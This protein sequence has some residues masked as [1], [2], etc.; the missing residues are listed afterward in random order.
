M[1]LCSKDV[2]NTCIVHSMHVHV[3]FLLVS[4]FVLRGIQNNSVRIDNTSF[5][6]NLHTSVI[7]YNESD[8]QF[9]FQ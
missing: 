7:I 5:F 6:S 1:K 9:V 3:Q 4:E 2:H 8:V